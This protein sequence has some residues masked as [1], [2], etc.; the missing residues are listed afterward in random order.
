MK[1][2]LKNE[3]KLTGKSHKKLFLGGGSFL[4][5]LSSHMTPRG[6]ISQ[7]TFMC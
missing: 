5:G 1:K 7:Q 3:K 4:C 2:I 6:D